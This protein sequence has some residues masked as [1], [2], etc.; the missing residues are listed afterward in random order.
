MH[1]RFEQFIREK[2]YLLNVSENTCR[3]YRYAFTCLQN[4]EPDEQYLRELIVRMRERGVSPETC[5]SVLRVINT[6]LRWSGSNVR[7]K[8]LKTGQKI[9]PTFTPGDIRK[10][11]H[12]KPRT[13]SQTRLQA[14]VL[15]LADTGLRIGEA[16]SL[17]WAD[18]DLDNL[19]LR[20]RHGKGDKARLVPFSLELRR[21]LWKHKKEGRG[22][23]FA[24]R[25]GKALMHR[26]TL[27]DVKLLCLKVGVTP[28]R[29]LLHA[30]RHSFSIHYLRKG[31]SVFHLQRILGHS[32]LDM[33][34]RYANLSVE[35]LQAV[36]QRMSLLAA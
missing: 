3:W 17:E 10:F 12:F 33:T 25:D 30:F 15:L 4:P 32:T 36:H 1:P 26:N 22:L 5:N 34:R 8:K 21:V 14:L 9:P 19:L 27:R 29:R 18:V 23:V 20:V 6:Y 31:G 16:L 2:R 28:P 11:Q 7:M 13:P 24:T 35:D